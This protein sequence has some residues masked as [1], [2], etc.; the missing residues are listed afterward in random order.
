MRK[1]RFALPVAA[2]ALVATLAACGPL[3]SG[4]PG[5]IP[6]GAANPQARELY[7]MVNADRGRVGL[8][9][10][11]W[12]NELGGLAQN[13]SNQMAASGSMSHQNLGAI[14]NSP[15]FGQFSG[16]GENVISGWCGMSAGEIHQAW[17]NSALHRAN[18]LGNFGAIGIGIACNGS[19]LFATEDFGR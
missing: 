11:G 12:N 5:S 15:G 19:S 3:K 9:P 16:L 8:G 13:W 14:L 4:P 7:S 10:L 1:I 17:M 2:L 6:F 18:I